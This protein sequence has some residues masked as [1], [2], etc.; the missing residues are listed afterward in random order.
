MKTLTIR[1][2][3]QLAERLEQESRDRGMSKSDVVRERL[4][5][6]PARQRL[7]SGLERILEASWSAE[8]PSQRRKR[9][10]SPHKRRLVDAIGAKKLSR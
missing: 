6:D 10:G 5:G 2:P 8:Q 7:D 4:S 9:R 1:L 3:D